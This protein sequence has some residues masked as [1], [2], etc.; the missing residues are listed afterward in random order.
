MAQQIGTHMSR[1]SGL[2]DTLEQTCAIDGPNLRKA[3]R[4]HTAEAV[5]RIDAAATPKWLP[6]QRGGY[7]ARFT[8]SLIELLAAVGSIHHPEKIGAKWHMRQVLRSAGAGL[9]YAR[10]GGAPTLVEAVRADALTLA[11]AARIGN[12][13][14]E[15]LDVTSV[16]DPTRQA[17]ARRFDA[18][19]SMIAWEGPGAICVHVGISSPTLALHLA[20]V[21]STLE[22]LSPMDPAPKPSYAPA[23]AGQ[24]QAG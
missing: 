6:H 11:D 21:T 12:A 9:A 23:P 17:V 19:T 18:N 22:R 3:F 13:A 7:G 8:F 10:A 24:S 20:S 5:A 15:L 14:A 1:A 16:I 4:Q 2:V